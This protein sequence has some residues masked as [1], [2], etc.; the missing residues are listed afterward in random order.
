MT[1][2]L[3]HATWTP[4][5]ILLF[6]LL[7]RPASNPFRACGRALRTA[8]A[9]RG[10]RIVAAV[11]AGVL[12]VNV[13]ECAVDPAVSAS[14]GYDMTPWVRS[15]EGDWIERVQ[16]VLPRGSLGFLAWF[17]LSG[18]IA[19]IAAPLVVWTVER[20]SREV[21]EYTGGFL[22]NYALAIPFYL[23][24]PVQE[25]G[26]SAVSEALP[27]LDVPWP[28]IS[29]EMRRGS[30]LDNCF[31]SL[32]VSLTTTVCWFAHR[33]GPRGLRILAWVAA[34]LTAFTVM[35]LGIHW[36]LDVV[37]GVPF[38]ILCALVGA[39]LGRRYVASQRAAWRA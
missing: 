13:L 10:G 7:A 8:V 1:L 38:G 28:G 24:F 36:A 37:A 3:L 33:H 11:F 16:S 5:S 35:A 39:W 18:Y 23:L 26:W 29:E 2:T 15:I 14:L 12:A 20:R 17:Y 31:P 32:H 25:V 30:A 22:A 9:T 21:A 19:V 34:I 27:L 6:V 4:L